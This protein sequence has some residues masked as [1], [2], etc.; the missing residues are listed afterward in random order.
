MKRV[1]IVG[2]GDMG[3]AMAKNLLKA[4]F[5][6]S[7]FDLRQERLDLLTEA[8]GKAAA[9][10]A[11]VGANSDTVFVMVLNGSMEGEVRAWRMAH[12]EGILNGLV[13]LAAAGVGHWT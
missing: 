11:D 6:L 8:G 2:L 5:E 13:C 3:I 12:L 9:S 4:G 10:I 1:G 7:G